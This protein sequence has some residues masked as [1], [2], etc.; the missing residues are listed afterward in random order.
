MAFKNKLFD[1]V[2]DEPVINPLIVNLGP[3]KKLYKKDKSVDK[4]KYKSQLQY[5]FYMG[6]YDSPIYNM[7]TEEKK[8]MACELSF[9]NKNVSRNITLLLQEALNLYIKCQSTVERRTLDSNVIS[10]DSLNNNL[11]NMRQ[12]SDTLFKILDELDKEIANTTDVED[13]VMYFEKKQSLEQAMLNNSKTISD[14]ISKSSK[15]LETIIDL[16]QKANK[17][18]SELESTID[19]FLIDEFIIEKE[20]KIL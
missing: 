3:F 17:A 5:C 10:C 18:H 9:G 7:E 16:R 2:D 8:L 20:N 12:S 14:L 15:L 4:N 13:K 19:D 11:K 1:I 6:D